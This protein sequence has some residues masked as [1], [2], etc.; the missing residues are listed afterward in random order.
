[1][2]YTDIQQIKHHLKS[3]TRVEDVSGDWFEKIFFNDFEIHLSAGPAS[4]SEPVTYL[5]NLLYYQSIQVAI[6]ETVKQQLHAIAPLSD[7]RFRNFSWSKYFIYSDYKGERNS[8]IGTRIPLDEV[9]QLIREIYKTS[10]LKIF[11]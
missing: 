9:C 10:R 11:F 4:F 7:D 3:L 6:Y 8:Y 5:N 2:D 1:M